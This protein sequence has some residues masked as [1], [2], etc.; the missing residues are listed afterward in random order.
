MNELIKTIK[1]SFSTSYEA[2]RYGISALI[3][4]IL[5]IVIVLMVMKFA[6]VQEDYACLGSMLSLIM[7][8]GLLFF[9]GIFTISN[10]FNLAVSM[11]KTRKYFVPAK[12][13]ALIVDMIVVLLIYK[14]V[15]VVELTLYSSLYPSAVC[16]I[17]FNVMK[18][19]SVLML[20]VILAVPA[21]ILLFGGLFMVFSTKF[22]WILWGLWMI[23]C[24]G[25]PRMLSVAVEQPDTPQGRLGTS[26]I[27]WFRGISPDY[28]A[29][30]LFVITVAAF[31][32]AMLLLRKQR[33]TV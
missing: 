10:D 24:I 23:G 4:G 3:G 8:V 1:Q 31:V 2:I 9:V 27:N 7:G 25:G 17:A 28:F 26:L 16:E 11:G 6:G 14:L 30:A 5:G 29:V 19:G 12:Y 33:V 22:F 21:L 18:G 13:L 32:G 20:A 15:N